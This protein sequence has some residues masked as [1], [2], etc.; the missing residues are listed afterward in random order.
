M[1]PRIAGRGKTSTFEANGA[2]PGSAGFIRIL[3]FFHG[4]LPT[5]RVNGTRGAP[6]NH[7]SDAKLK[8]ESRL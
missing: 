6:E 4:V 2:E 1:F 8:K 7:E 5:T 3:N